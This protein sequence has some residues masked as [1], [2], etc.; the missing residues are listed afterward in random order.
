MTKKKKHKKK[1][2]KG[3]SLNY[4]MIVTIGG[5]FHLIVYFLL[6]LT[7]YSDTL[8]WLSLIAGGI[9]LGIYFILKMEILNPKSYRKIE[10]IKLKLYISVIT[11]LIF[12]G[13]TV[14]FGNILNGTL[15]GLNYLGKNNELKSSE[16][17]IEKIVQNK[18]G[19][20]KRIRRNNP[21]VYYENNGKRISRDLTERYSLK[22]NYS[23]FKTINFITYK[24]LLGFD[25]MKNYELKK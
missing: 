1:K 14:I 20:R 17:N 12:L 8:L 4:K 22:K 3:K 5:I 18:T 24:G 15:L 11:L 23:E 16:F 13:S 6:D 9:P 21:R 2:K 25:I 10:G 19:G 7:F